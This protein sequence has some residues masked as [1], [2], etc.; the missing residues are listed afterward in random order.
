MRFLFY[1]KQETV[2]LN[3]ALRMNYTVIV[4]LLLIRFTVDYE[5]QAEF[6]NGEWFPISAREVRRLRPKTWRKSLDRFGNMIFTMI[7]LLLIF[8]WWKCSIFM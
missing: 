2:Y 6:E 4:F 1:K 5:F 7:V 8:T 3:P